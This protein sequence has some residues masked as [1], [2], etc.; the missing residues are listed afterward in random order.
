MLSIVLLETVLLLRTI[1]VRNSPRWRK[2]KGAQ[3]VL[4]FPWE[5][6][7]LR[8][9]RE[10]LLIRHH[11]KFFDTLCTRDLNFKTLTQLV[12]HGFTI[13][14]EIAVKKSV[15]N[16]C[17][18]PMLFR[19][20]Y[21]VPCLKRLRCVRVFLRLLVYPGFARFVYWARPRNSIMLGRDPSFLFYAT[22]HSPMRHLSKN[23]FIFQELQ[24]VPTLLGLRISH[25]FGQH[26]VDASYRWNERHRLL[27][28]VI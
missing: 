3:K 23:F 5:D 24:L 25:C 15:N 21:W 10:A 12:D 8:R 1:M 20:S 4:V 16:Q 2:W 22:I 6:G 28:D 27:C 26:C 17:C 9:L 7:P 18:N 19:K 11:S 13:S 14:M